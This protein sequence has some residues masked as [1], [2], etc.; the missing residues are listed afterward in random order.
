MTTDL[1]TVPELRESLE[2][3]ACDREAAE[4]VA[5]GLWDAKAENTRRSYVS[6]WRRFQAWADPG[7]HRTPPAP[8]KPWP[9]ISQRPASPRPLWRRPAPPQGCRR[10]T[11]LPATRRWPMPWPGSGRRSGCPGAAAGSVGIAGNR[12]QARRPRS[13]QHWGPGRRRTQTLRTRRPHPGGRGAMGRRHGP[14]D[15]TGGKNQVEPATV[16]VPPATIRDLGEIRPA[17]ADPEAPVFGL[18][19]EAFANPSARHSAARRPG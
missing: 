4:A 5:S 7:G 14:A 15:D 18:I 2:L 10:P 12:P 11:T 13:G 8:S 9:F 17:G 1:A 3:S 19:G 6:A 16:A